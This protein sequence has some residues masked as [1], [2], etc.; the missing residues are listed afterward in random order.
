MLFQ[1]DRTIFEYT[2]FDE[3]LYVITSYNTN[4]NI[5]RMYNSDTDYLRGQEEYFR[6]GSIITSEQYE[7]YISPL[8]PKFKGSFI[9]GMTRD[10]DYACNITNEKDNQTSVRAQ[11]VHIGYIRGIPNAL[12]EYRRRQI[13]QR[14]MM[15][16]QSNLVDD[17]I[18]IIAQNVI[19]LNNQSG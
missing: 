9:A 8:N 11:L 17:V 19:T 16:A 15:F 18:K 10:E 7:K 14:I 3:L 13:I 4:T 1:D 6:S 2:Y 12:Y 5:Y